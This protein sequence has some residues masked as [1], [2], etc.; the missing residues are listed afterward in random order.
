MYNRLAKLGP[1]VRT[2]PLFI[3]SSTDRIAARQN[4]IVKLNGRQSAGALAAISKAY[5]SS[6]D[7]AT[8]NYEFLDDAYAKNYHRVQRMTTMVSGTT[9][10][11]ILISLFGLFSMVAFSI[12]NRT[13]E[14]GIRKVFGVTFFSLQWTLSRSFLY[15]I[16]VSL[17]VAI[18]LAYWI[19]N[20][21]LGSFYNAMP[22]TWVQALFTAGIIYLCTFGIALLKGVSTANM[23]PVDILRSH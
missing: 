21:A 19:M 12:S 14:I 6:F 1:A 18:P 16:T 9:A 15:I 8:M 5:T 11:I 4:F 10:F 13:K 23:N 17:L 7:S 22:L 2:R 3:Q 20:E